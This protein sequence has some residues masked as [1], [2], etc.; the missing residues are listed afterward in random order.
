[1]NEIID[2]K[3]KGKEL[4]KRSDFSGFIENTNLDK[5]IATLAPKVELKAEQDKKVKLM[6]LF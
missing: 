4:D 3:M 6:G 5:K 2:N 1:M